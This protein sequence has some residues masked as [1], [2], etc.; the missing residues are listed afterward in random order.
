MLFLIVGVIY[1]RAHHRRIDG[2]GGL[3]SVMPVYTG[4]M[5]LAFFAAMG[6]PGL[7]AFI[8]EILV[9]LGA[10]RDYKIPTLFGAAT[11]ILTAGYL[12]WTIQQMFLGTPREDY[13]RLHLSEIS[14]RELFTL[15]PLGVIVVVLGVYP[16]A[17]LDLLNGSLQ[18]LNATVLA[19]AQ[20]T[21][22]ALH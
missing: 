20:G 6:L 12:L 2:F 16:H 3:A 22:V 19:A 15:V 4:V 14:G 7:S 11:V 10:W 17:I 1:D 5:A 18:H 21:T 13:A 8:S 9:L